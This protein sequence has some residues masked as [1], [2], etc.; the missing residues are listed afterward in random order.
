MENLINKYLIDPDS[1]EVF[2]NSTRFMKNAKVKNNS[3][4]I[5]EDENRYSSIL[6]KYLVKYFEEELT[7]KDILELVETVS[8]YNEQIDKY[9]ENNADLSF[10]I[11]GYTDDISS[12][13][14]VRYNCQ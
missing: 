1:Y 7:N 6:G 4:K 14:I 5:Y 9:W 11:W 13:I 12:I 3:K 10:A 2:D 8:E